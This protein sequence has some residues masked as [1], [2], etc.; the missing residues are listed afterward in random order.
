M[1]ESTTQREIRAKLGS[2]KLPFFRYQV[3]TFLTSEGAMVN[4]GV[5]GVSDLIGITPYTITPEDVGR[6]V[7]IFTALEVKK[8]RGGRVSEEQ[9]AF[10]RTVNRLGG[11]GAV[12]K[13]AADAE[14]VVTEM[15]KCKLVAL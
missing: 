15:W 7:G 4:I 9:K 2:M 1:N 11:I 8:P 6:T 14:S 12:V 13:S 5:K 3:G 10:L